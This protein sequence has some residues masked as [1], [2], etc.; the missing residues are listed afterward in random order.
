MQRRRGYT[1]RYQRRKSD[2]T[3][4]SHSVGAEEEKS[5]RQTDRDVPFSVRLF[6]MISTRKDEHKMELKTPLYEQHVA[7][8]GKIVSFG[9]YLLPVEYGTG[10]IA[11]HTAVREACGLFDVS[12]MGEVLIQGTGALNT[13]NHLLTNSY[14]SL[15]DGRVRYSPMCNERGGVV[16]DLIVYKIHDNCYFVVVNAA[17]KDKDVAHM[18]ANLLADTTLTDISDQVAQL[19]LQGPRS[20]EILS[21]LV[22]AEAIPEKYYSFHKEPVMV[23]GVKCLISRTGYTGS[24][25][26]ELYCGSDQAVTLWTRLLEAGKSYGLIPCGLGARDTLR[27]EASMPLYGHEMDDD[28]SP[29]EAALGFAVKLNKPEFI[30]REAL[31]KPERNTRTRIGLKAVGRGILREHQ[32]VL[33][34][35]KEIGHTTSGTFCPYLKN[36]YAMAL[37]ENGSAELGDTVEVVVRNR[38]VAAE[39]V[40]LPFFKL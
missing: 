4:E 25:G 5:F 15:A 31:L 36:A 1:L 2:S 12:H 16:D 34:D 28:V 24:W 23:C 8:G 38:K 29:I 11:E 18:S 13:L 20:K 3:L 19:A 33:K 37:V 22:P 7:C 35:G 17:N 26:Y 30:G 14:D 6:L 40:A 39:V 21:D 27:L 10:V 9:G 32:T